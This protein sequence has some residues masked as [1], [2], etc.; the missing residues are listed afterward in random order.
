MDVRLLFLSSLCAH[1]LLLQRGMWSVS[2]G[3]KRE[4]LICLWG[5]REGKEVRGIWGSM[6]A[7]FF[8]RQEEEEE[9]FIPLTSRSVSL[10]PSFPSELSSRGR[11]GGTLLYTPSQPPMVF[12]PISRV[13]AFVHPFLSHRPERKLEEGEKKINSISF[14]RRGETKEK[15]APRGKGE[16]KEGEREKRG[17]KNSGGGSKGRRREGGL[18]GAK[19]C[20]QLSPSSSSVISAPFSA[21]LAA[22]AGYR[23]RGGDGR[24]SNCRSL[25]ETN[26]YL[27]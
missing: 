10:A 12:F 14:P 4:K 15:G 2:A 26:C 27:G 24:R 20:L 5:S 21:S 13:G 18:E 3:I 11:R 7:S 1:S 25:F 8:E 22:G 17:N 23:L 9:V 6:A 19:L 16:E